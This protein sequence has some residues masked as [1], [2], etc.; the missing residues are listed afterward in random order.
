QKY[1]GGSSFQEVDGH[2]GQLEPGQRWHQM[3]HDAEFLAVLSLIGQDETLMAKVSVH[4]P[5]DI[6]RVEG[7]LNGRKSDWRGENGN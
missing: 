7:L 2:A 6:E 4:F 3:R 1:G 5:E